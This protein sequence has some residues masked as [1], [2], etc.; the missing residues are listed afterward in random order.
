MLKT[1]QLTVRSWDFG[2]DAIERMRVAQP[3]SMLDAD[4]EYGL[5]PT[6]WSAIST[7]RGY[8]S[9]YEVPGT[10]FDVATVTSDASAGT[11]GIGSSLITV[12]TVGPH[13]FEAGQPLTITGFD[14][15]VQGASRAAGSFTVNTVSQHNTIYILRKSKSWTS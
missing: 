9:I 14:N 13:G 12:T 8:P 15:G 10:D 2:T 1:T 11:Q 7:Q 3:E 4:F 6:K 5:Q